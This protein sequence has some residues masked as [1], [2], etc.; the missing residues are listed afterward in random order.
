MRKSTAVF[1][2]ALL[3]ASILRP[4]AHAETPPPI[5]FVPYATSHGNWPAFECKYKDKQNVEKLVQFAPYSL[6]E[7]YWMGEKAADP[8]KWTAIVQAATKHGGGDGWGY[9]IINEDSSLMEFMTGEEI[10]A[11][12]T[13]DA[14]QVSFHTI[15]PLD[16]AF[17]MRKSWMIFDKKSGNG[18]AVITSRAFPLQKMKTYLEISAYDCKEMDQ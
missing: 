1:V 15:L 17:G 3:V 8:A 9:S 5:D 10:T 4:S 2:L 11:S 13:A 14:F 6:E 7:S 16:N 12:N 18:S